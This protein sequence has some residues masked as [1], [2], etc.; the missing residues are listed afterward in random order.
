MDLIALPVLAVVLIRAFAHAPTWG[1]DV[2]DFLR[3]LRRFRD[4]N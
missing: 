1:R 2:L 3:D 4:G